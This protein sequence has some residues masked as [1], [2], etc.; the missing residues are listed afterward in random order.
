MTAFLMRP[1]VRASALLG[2]GALL[3][4]LYARGQW[5]LG[6]VALLPWLMWLDTP[7]P[8]GR[9]LLRAWLLSLAFALA[10]FGWFGTAM[11]HY[12]QWPQPAGWLVL[13]LI[14]PLMQP[15]LMAWALVRQGLGARQRPLLG[16]VVASA[17]WVGMEWAV[18]KVLGDTLGHGLYPAAQ[19][20]QAAAL[21]GAAGL[22][23]LLLLV[24]EALAA[25]LAQG[26]NHR[27]APGRRPASA[28][29][30]PAAAALLLPL[31]A[32]LYG[33]QR[34][35]PALAAETPQ[36]RVGLVQANMA[37]YERRREAQGTY[38]VVR[39]VL[40]THYA[41][42]Y[43][44][45]ERQRADAVLW[46]ETIYPTTFG[47]PKSEA[48]AQ[49]DQE[50]VSIVNAAGVPFVFGTYD[51]DGAG[52][53]NAAAFVQ[54]QQ[55]LLGMYRKARLFPL[56]ESVPAWLDGPL[57]QRWL[58][59]AGRWQAGSG[60]RVFPLRLR[61]GREVPVQPLICR[62][63][64]D[65]A[66]ALAGARLGA[67]A[68]LTMS[69]DAWFSADPLGARLHEAA[70][71]FRSIETG[72]PQFRVTTNGY[73]AVIDARGTVHARG[74]FGQRTLVVG[75]LPVPEVVP[76]LMVRWGDW[77][78]AASVALLGLLGAAALLR[79]VLPAAPVVPAFAWPVRVRVLPAG[80]RWP[81]AALRG[82]A[83]LSLLGLGLAWGLDEG[84]RSQG[85]QQ[86][87][88]FAALVV[89]PELAAWLLLAAWAAELRLAGERLVIESRGT[90]TQ[91]WPLGALQGMDVWRLPWPG[92]GLTLS[93]AEGKTWHLVTAR[94]QALQEALEAARTVGGS[95]EP[96]G[97]R[98]RAD[99]YAWARQWRPR[100]RLARPLWKFVL[101]P[102]LLATPAFAL[103]QHI[104]YGGFLGELYSYGLVAYLRAFALWWAAWALG[105]AVTAA[106]LRLL[107][108]GG[109]WLG[110]WWQPQG[111]LRLRLRLEQAG[112]ALLY[113]GLPLWLLMKLLGR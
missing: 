71:A 104:A 64:T 19:L 39:E 73:S 50:I 31:A 61:D 95:A 90:P 74:D 107:I 43:D 86:L 32:V 24:N 100:L 59:W 92:P 108:E 9:R 66:L 69:N 88:L 29:A 44:A 57:L 113:A 2:G 26:L 37:D 42:S 55:G 7:A 48:G 17:T 45:V 5:W 106:V 38:A 76:T 112:L 13:V 51:R 25:L 85:L 3:L 21:G 80:L 8:W 34:E 40:D 6:F 79:R 111:A 54:P 28:L 27:S 15:Q 105:V 56:T 97:E 47:Q 35:A 103:H 1:G 41:M 99:W 96:Q 70:A 10:G 77:V 30:R 14:A 46:S 98:S 22:T 75:A 20:R 52:E 87:R 16:A 94:P 101:L 49:L 93:S 67:R 33:S 72:L 68:M 53:Y 102:L 18:P 36:L 91:G 63:D 12:A 110:L 81:L 11:A 62:D 60:A 82:I 78:G 65:S 83:R 89:A 109:A 4:A 84:F 23:G 58:P